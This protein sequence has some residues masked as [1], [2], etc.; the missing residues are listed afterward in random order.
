MLDYGLAIWTLCAVNLGLNVG[1]LVALKR[2]R[3]RLVKK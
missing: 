2:V 3:D 1:I